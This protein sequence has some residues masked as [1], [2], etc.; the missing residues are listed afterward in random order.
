MDEAPNDHAWRALMEAEASSSLPEAVAAAIYET[1]DAPACYLGLRDGRVVDSRLTVDGRS[2]E[3]LDPRILER[4][5]AFQPCSPRQFETLAQPSPL[6]A[7]HLFDAEPDR[8]DA[9]RSEVLSLAGMGHQLRALLFG[10]R[11][12]LLAWVAALRE[13]GA[14]EF[15]QEDALKLSRVLTPALA[16]LRHKARFSR[17]PVEAAHLCALVDAMEAPVLIVSARRA[18]LHANPTARRLGA[19]RAWLRG[20]EVPVSVLTRLRADGEEVAVI[21]FDLAS[22]RGFALL[23]PTPPKALPP[24][25]ARVAEL[26]AQGQ[27]DKDIARATG[28]AVA[29]IRTYVRSI[30]AHFGVSSR[31]EL[32]ARLRPQR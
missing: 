23:E 31:G 18:I 5:R 22:P 11:G 30:F 9:Y 12:E 6:S 7:R 16:T 4:A 15:D 8:L 24:R 27:A 20:D 14:P 10:E 2:M 21:R 28:L 13:P 1:L 25:L 19:W 3:P 26:L 32:A 17:S 29:S